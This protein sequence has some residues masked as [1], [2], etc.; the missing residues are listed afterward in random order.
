MKRSA[1]RRS[2]NLAAAAAFAVL[3]ACGG[4]DTPEPTT[5]SSPDPADPAAGAVGS[6]PDALEQAERGA[7]VYEASCG[8]CHGDAGEGAGNN[9]PVVGAGVLA[10][11]AHAGEILSYVMETM[12]ADDPGGLSV[13]EFQDVVA[14]MLQQSGIDLVGKSVTPATG[15]DITF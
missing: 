4:A 14:F 8:F 5:P 7:E 11:Y 2:I 10:S 9:P 12:P 3:A 13:D 1:M 6:G 15:A